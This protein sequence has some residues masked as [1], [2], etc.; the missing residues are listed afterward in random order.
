MLLTTHYMEEADRL[1][2]RLAIIDDG[3]IAASGSP[4]ELKRS[5]GGDQ[6]TLTL[7]PTEAGL[8]GAQ[9][10]V[11]GRLTGIDGVAGIERTADGV[12][13][14]VRDAAVV[15]TVLRQLDGGPTVT[16]IAVTEPT[17]E[18]VFLAL[19]GRTIRHEAAD[20]PLEL[21]W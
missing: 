18:D 20:Q 19:T 17:L 5:I 16:R 12:R 14:S 7:A 10:A 8:T 6:V 1:C 9:D 3:R 2:A 11:I 21:G 15:P 4:A 13:L